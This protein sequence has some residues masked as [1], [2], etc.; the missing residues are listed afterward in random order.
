MKIIYP[1][2]A[3]LFL[4]FGSCKPDHYEQPGKGGNATVVVFPQHHEV[5]K[6]I[7]NGKVYILYAYTNAPANGIYDDSAICT[8]H[9]SLLS[10]SFT[11]L[12]DGNY[13]FLS[14][15]YD[16]SIHQEVIGGAPYRV[17]S[18]TVQSF[19]LPVSER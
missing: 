2:I 17:S 4:M 16:T 13:Y 19:N 11:N 9:D 14:T 10:C 3:A 15:G 12:S 5:A 1:I 8:N 6:N 18:Q 7:I